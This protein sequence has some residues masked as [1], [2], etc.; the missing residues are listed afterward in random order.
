MAHLQGIRT[1]G[2][3][4]PP[5]QKLTEHHTISVHQSNSTVGFKNFASN[6]SHQICCPSQSTLSNKL[7]S[8][9]ICPSKFDL[10]HHSGTLI[11]TFGTKF[12]FTAMPSTKESTNSLNY[13]QAAVQSTD[14][15]VPAQTSDYS[16]E[17]AEVSP[18]RQV[19]HMKSSLRKI[20][21]YY[22]E[23]DL[24]E[25]QEDMKRKEIAKKLQ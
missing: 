10:Y 9:S 2:A 16:I 7:L 6:Q 11:N 18:Q 23:V 19:G 25:I 22:K 12:Q 14:Y 24:T 21:K 5:E 1:T 4:L 3:V 20:S 13:P 8:S 15:H 17:V